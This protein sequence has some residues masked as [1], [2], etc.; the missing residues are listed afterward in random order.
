MTLNLQEPGKPPPKMA[1]THVNR[2]HHF[3]DSI[4]FQASAVITINV[5][6]GRFDD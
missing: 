3:R 2:P 5:N 1:G 6:A 4:I